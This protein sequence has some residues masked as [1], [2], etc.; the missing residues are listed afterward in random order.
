MHVSKKTV[1][2]MSRR[3]IDISA[4]QYIISQLIL[5]IKLKLCF[6][7]MD[8]NQIS[9]ELG[10]TEPSNMTNFFKKYTELSPRKF[11]SMNANSD[12]DWIRSESRDLDSIA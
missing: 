1:N 6:E 11:R 8:I 3:A 12:Y 4:K 9:D 2:L 5:K 7:K 10:F